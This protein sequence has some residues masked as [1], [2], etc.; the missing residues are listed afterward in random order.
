MQG[1]PPLGFYN[2]AVLSR[3]AWEDRYFRD[4]SS[5]ATSEDD[6][7]V[8]QLSGDPEDSGLLP[9]GGPLSTG[10]PKRQTIEQHLKCY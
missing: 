3:N 10:L 2:Y 8:V 5:I 7:P 6:C 4:Y 1:V 9:I